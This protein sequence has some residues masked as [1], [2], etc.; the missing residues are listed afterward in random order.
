MSLGET[1]AWVTN[2]DVGL[3]AYVTPRERPVPLAVESLTTSDLIVRGSAGESVVFDY[4]VYGLRLGFEETTVVQEKTQEARIPSMADHRRRYEHHP[5]L[6]QFTALARFGRMPS[7][8][9]P[10]P[11][12]GAAAQA[13]RAAVE[14]FDPAIHGRPRA[15]REPDP[16]SVGEPTAGT[17]ISPRPSLQRTTPVSGVGAPPAPIVTRDAAVT[18]GVAT[19]TAAQPGPL[20]PALTR[21]RAR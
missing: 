3:T 15:D 16:V 21:R 8:A 2:P 11:R 14:E 5:E 17:A 9:G 20:L 18:E 10:P 12:D 19:S 13:L 4:I 6:R 7:A 1:F